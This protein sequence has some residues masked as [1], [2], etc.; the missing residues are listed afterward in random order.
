LPQ[1]HRKHRNYNYYKEDL[2]DLADP[3]DT[4]NFGTASISLLNTGPAQL[5]SQ[6]KKRRSYAVPYYPADP[7]IRRIFFMV[8]VVSVLSVF[9]WQSKTIFSLESIYTERRDIESRPATRQQIGLNFTNHAR[10]FEP[11]A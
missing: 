4:Q 11:V 10:E 9:L 6:N 8:V 7:L 1:R 3:A 2:T 5:R